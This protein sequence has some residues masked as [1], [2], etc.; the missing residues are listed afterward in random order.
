MTLMN[1][2]DFN[3]ILNDGITIYSSGSTGEAKPYFQ[4]PQKI[5]AANTVAREVLGVSA[6][7]NIYTCTRL[8]HAGGLFVQTLPGFE[9]GANICINAFSPYEFVKKIPYY[10]QSFVT[11]KHAKAIMLT[12][13]FR[14]LDLT[15]TTILIGSE[16]VTWDIIEGFVSRGCKLVADWGMSEIGPVA[17]NY[18]F[19]S[20]DQVEYVKSLCPVGATVLGDKFYCDYKIVDGEL[21]VAGDICIYDDWYHTK[22]TVIDVDGILFYTGRTNK[23]VDFDNPLKG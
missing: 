13:G 2:I 15:G 22:D 16:P 1:N 19:E 14:E 9:V 5:K 23:E 3:A 6:T 21:V 10:D 20:M 17:I 18:T 12:K 4:S 7:S 8:T 11:P